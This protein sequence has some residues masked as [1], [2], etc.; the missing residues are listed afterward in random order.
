MNFDLT[1]LEGRRKFYRS[2]V[3]FNLRSSVL[4]TEPICEWC[5]SKGIIRAATEVHHKIDIAVNPTMSH[6]CNLNN[7]QSLCLSC[8]NE[9]TFQGNNEKKLKPIYKWK[10]KDS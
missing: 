4:T 5:K 10:E 3:W 2:G 6:A 9:H 8:H 1:T 7:L